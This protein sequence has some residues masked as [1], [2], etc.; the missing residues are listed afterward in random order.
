MQQEG[1]L[2][3]RLT[4]R[5][6][7]CPEEFLLPP[8]TVAG[9][10]IHVAA[11][12]ADHL[13]K[14]GMQ[15]DV[16]AIQ[17]RFGPAVVGWRQDGNWLRMVAIGVWLL[18]E[19]WFLARP[20]LAVHVRQFWEAGLQAL[21][22]VVDAKTVVAD[23]DRRE[24]FARLCLKHLGLRPAGETIEYA[25]DRLGTLDSVERVRVVREMRPAE[26]RARQVREAL[27]KQAAQ[28]AAAKASRE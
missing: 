20:D 14:I 12:V 22:R 2:L 8:M 23:P 17:E 6:S 11:L 9:G 13:R 18:E 7:E 24:E 28:A 4:R 15:P 3:E 1:P 5:L 10:T 16:P 26:A 25:T 19:D 27:A 21:S